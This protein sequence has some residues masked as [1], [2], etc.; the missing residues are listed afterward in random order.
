MEEN[1]GLCPAMD[2]NTFNCD[3]DNKTFV[4]E[5]GKAYIQQFTE[6]CQRWLWSR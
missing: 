2:W 6:V 5:I 3:C 4:E 1:G